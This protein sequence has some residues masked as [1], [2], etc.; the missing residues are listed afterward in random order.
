VNSTAFIKNTD[1]ERAPG[2]F[3]TLILEEDGSTIWGY[4]MQMQDPVMG[5][6]KTV[7][8]LDANGKVTG[9][10]TGFFTPLSHGHGG[11]LRV[12]VTAL[13]TLPK[14][15]ALKLDGAAAL[16]VAKLESAPN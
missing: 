15:S 7:E 14:D 3:R 16:G 6:K 10:I 9:K 5:E 4:S 13:A 2:T 1:P 8:V 12:R 11:F